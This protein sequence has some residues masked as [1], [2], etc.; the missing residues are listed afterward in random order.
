VTI[1]DNIPHGLLDA[2]RTC[3][4]AT[5]GRDGTPLTWPVSPWRQA[6]GTLLVTASVGFAQKAL[7]VRRDA[8]VGLLF[9]DPTGSGLD[10]PPQLF[11]HG[12]AEC[13]TEL[14]TSPEG[15]EKYWSTLY[16]RQPSSRGYALPGIRSLMD[17]YYMRLLITVTPAYVE[18]RPSGTAVALPPDS[19]APGSPE[20]AQAWSRAEQAGIPGA[21]Q[22]ARYPTAVLGALDTQGAVALVRTTP[23]P[24]GDRF[25]V[26]AAP[27]VDLAAGPAS[28]LAHRHDEKLSKARYV[29][30]CGQIAR[31]QAPAGD[32]DWL[33][34]PDRVVEP[35]G[36]GSPASA[37]RSLRNARASAA[38]YLAKRALERPAVPWQQYRALARR[39]RPTR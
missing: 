23:Q 3:E 26:A 16:E 29:L 34:T 20:L 19:L 33:F 5:L 35:A 25:T 9:S 22:L 32:A 1:I 12:T 39:P 10:D 7:N 8:R 18:E 31:P 30:V 37:I 13:S 36:S 4:F 17:W 6:D 14:T 24:E 38:G 27:G 21:R 11:I 15:L 28:L 2:Y